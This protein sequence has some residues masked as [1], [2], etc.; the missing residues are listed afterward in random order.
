M[1]QKKS[2]RIRGGLVET[3]GLHKRCSVFEGV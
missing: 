2:L 1:N 3:K